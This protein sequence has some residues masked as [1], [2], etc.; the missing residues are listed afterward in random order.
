M[1]LENSKL[2]NLLPTEFEKQ[3]KFKLY[4][5]NIASKLRFLFLLKHTKK[6]LKQNPKVLFDKK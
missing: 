5:K 2:R 6:K 3:T 4:I 1:E